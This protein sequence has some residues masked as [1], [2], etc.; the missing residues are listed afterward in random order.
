MVL[1]H[2]VGVGELDGQLAFGHLGLQANL[3]LFERI[4]LVKIQRKVSINHLRLWTLFAHHR[5]LRH[6]RLL[7]HR[8]LVSFLLL[9]LLSLFTVHRLYY[10]VLN[11]VEVLNT[12][13]VFYH[14]FLQ[15]CLVAAK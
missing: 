3:L 14:Y 9:I 5:V 8:L 2:L 13:E 4:G 15:L 6:G 10:T 7:R 12:L 1:L 11:L